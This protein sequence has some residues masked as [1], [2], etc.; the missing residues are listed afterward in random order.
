MQGEGCSRFNIPSSSTY[1]SS[2]ACGFIFPFGHFR[3]AHAEWTRLLPS[4][5]VLFHNHVCHSAIH[6]G[7]IERFRWWS[8]IVMPV[9]RFDADS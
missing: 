1:A 7:S 4:S 8:L 9:V 6:Y 3:A 2:S 5:F